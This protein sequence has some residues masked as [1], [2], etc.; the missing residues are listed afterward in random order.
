M[1]A[2]VKNLR[3]SRRAIIKGGVLT[4]GFALTPKRLIPSSP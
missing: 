2:P 4:V 1:N 3:F